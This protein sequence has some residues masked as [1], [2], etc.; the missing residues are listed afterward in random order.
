MDESEGGEERVSLVYSGGCLGGFSHHGLRHIP[1]GVLSLIVPRC[2]I[3]VSCRSYVF[4]R[5][6]VR[7]WACFYVVSWL[8]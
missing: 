4:T 7:P 8:L 3:A 1:N 6:S 5:V 2:Y